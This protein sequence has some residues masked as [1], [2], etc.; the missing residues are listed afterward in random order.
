MKLAQFLQTQMDRLLEDWEE[1]ALELA[2]E[3][4]GEESISLRDHAREMLQFIIQDLLTAQTTEEST[5]KSLGN[6]VIPVSFAGEQHGLG[7]LEQGMTLLQVILELR[8]LRER[9]TRLWGDEQQGL[10]TEDIYDLVRFNEAIDQLI[11]SSVSS[12]SAR[13]DQDKRLFEAVLN[14]SPDPFAL[15]DPDG[16]LLVLNKPMANLVGTPAQDHV[17]KTA[18]E[19]GLAFATQVHDAIAATVATSQ[20][21][22]GDFHGHLPSGRELYFDSQFIPVCND[23]DEVEAVALMSRNITARKKAE[24]QV[25]RSANFDSLTGIPNRRLFQDRLGQCLLEAE[26]GDR[27]F[28][29]LF[30][31]L[32]RFKE[33][34]DRLGHKAGDR[35]LEQVAKRLAKNVRTVD[36][37]ARLGGDEFTVILKNTGREGAMRAA[38]ALLADLERAFDVDSQRVHLSGSIGLTLF[39]DDGK[40]GD[41]LMH[42]ADQAMYAAKKQGGHQIQ[43]YQSWMEPNESERMRLHR[44]LGD[45]IREDQLE[46]Y[47]QPIIDI[48]T[49]AI[50]RAE[51]LLRWNHPDKGQ[52][53]PAT[54]LII[55]EPDGMMDSIN[56]YVLKQAVTC[57]LRWRNQEDEPFPIHINESPASFFTPTLV[58]QWWARLMESDLEGSR[59]TIE[60]TP[61]SLSNLVACGIDPVESCGLADLRLRLAIDDFGI[62]PFSIAALQD[63]QVGS[64]KVGRTLINKTGQDGDADRILKAIIGMAHAID[65]QV[66]AEGVER[67]AQLQFL[68]REGCDY[69]QGYLF[70]KPLCQDDFE[71]LLGR[72]RQ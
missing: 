19:L 63:C 40:D 42:N 12:Y 68:A 66:V 2:R 65:I 20:P 37:V 58:E 28:A 52:L 13:K 9:V 70:S 53:T 56:S 18:L 46:V 61:I 8:A 38:K 69:A 27:S 50:S 49:G 21:Q 51:A 48:R 35:L 3:S 34:N 62:E 67:E 10:T 23:R 7:R 59:I 71:A 25:W 54:F 26:R 47:Y 29:L 60:L 6:A 11:A 41:Q 15:F 5:R 31:D 43:I 45:A 17:G 72:L 30:I 4:L 57:S 64:I 22:R 24:H 44:E 16:K 33:A 14:V 39:P 55:A 36:T 1:A 32:D